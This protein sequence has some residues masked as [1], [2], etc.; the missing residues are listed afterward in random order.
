MTD[1]ARFLTVEDLVALNQNVLAYGGGTHGV[2]YE[3]GLGY[4]VDRPFLTFDGQ[5]MFPS[6]YDKAA[7]LVE[8][9]IRSHPFVDGN[10]RTAL[11]AGLTL[12]EILTG[13]SPVIPAEESAQA[14]VA[15]AENEWGAAEFSLWLREKAESEAD[16]ALYGDVTREIRGFIEESEPLLQKASSTTLGRVFVHGANIFTTI[17][18]EVIEGAQRTTV[19]KN[20]LA[21]A[22][23]NPATPPRRL[24]EL[25]AE[26]AR[27][28]EVHGARMAASKELSDF[29]DRDKALLPEQD[30]D[31]GEEE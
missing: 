9:L 25:E 4:A 6:P 29:L 2:R 8:S 11:V 24:H 15:V 12:L 13:R 5:F 31:E 17:N 3:N 28:S 1:S 21:A 26:E 10:K 27:A 16:P 30:M 20:A 22:I 18:E 19:A 7:A 23:R 14:C